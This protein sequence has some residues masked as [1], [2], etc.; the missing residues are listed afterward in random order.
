M[1]VDQNC[2]IGE[3][4]SH[5][6]ANNRSGRQTMAIL[7]L[8]A[9]DLMPRPHWRWDIALAGALALSA[10]L[11]AAFAVEWTGFDLWVSDRF[12][13]P[14]TQRWMIDFDRDFVTRQIFY[15]IPKFAMAGFS[16]VLVALLFGP[17]RWLGRHTRRALACAVTFWGFAATVALL[18]DHTD[19]YF[20]RQIER[21]QNASQLPPAGVWRAPGFAVPRIAYRRLW[22]PHDA[23]RPANAPRG[24]GFP[25]AHASTGF[26]LMGLA[27]LA[28]SHR[29]RVAWLITGSVV[30]WTLGLYQTVNGNH[31]LS[32]TL[33]TWGIAAAWLAALWLLWSPDRPDAGSA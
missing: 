3:I 26:F 23:S 33:V 21:Y 20:P 22:E 18:K 31:F 6:R 25:A 29:A 12:Y 32:H 5:D 14:V 4:G 9:R 7:M 27:A 16:A 1:I 2:E 28:S 13:N 10:S 24:R 30:G 17:Q 19:V 15:Q 11:L 8:M